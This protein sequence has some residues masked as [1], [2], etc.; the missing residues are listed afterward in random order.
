LSSSSG[1]NV[2]KGRYVAYTIT[3]ENRGSEN[4]DKTSVYLK[5]DPRLDGVEF[6]PA[7]SAFKND[8]IVWDLADFY[9]GEL[10]KIECVFKYSG[11]TDENLNM[12][13]SI[14][15][16]AG[17]A[18]PEDNESSLSQELSE[19]EYEFQKSII[20][21]GTGDSITLPDSAGAI[22]YIISFANYTSDTIFTVYV[23]DTIRL[24]HSMSFIQTT[25]SS[26]SVMTEAFP[27]APGQDIGI[28]VWTFEDINLY[29]NPGKNPEIVTHQ[30]FVS[31][32][33]GLNKNLSEGMVLSNRASVAFDYYD[34]QLTNWTYALV[35]N[36]RVGIQEIVLQSN[37]IVYPNPAGNSLSVE[38]GFQ[39][40]CEMQYDVQTIS[41][42]II[43]SGELHTNCEID[44][45]SLSPGIYVL[46]LKTE[47]GYYTI[48]FLKS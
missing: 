30:G 47:S 7:A 21:G 24:N 5:V 1:L 39:D 38:L 22:E 10:G 16:E 41:G 35:D 31:F 9:S 12:T 26:H 40:N 27:G 32:K 36:P 19:D 45:S 29:P 44:V 4:V 25:A 2:T 13:A 11:S 48:K 18:N 8:T 15:L 23:V 6:K 42:Q 34:P 3:Y 20:S 28:L 14:P 46:T 43:L 37:L 17:E 33:I